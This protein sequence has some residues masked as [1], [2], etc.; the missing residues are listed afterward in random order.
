[1]IPFALTSPHPKRLLGRSV[2]PLFCRALGRYQ[3]TDRHVY[4]ATGR[5]IRPS[6]AL[7]VQYTYISRLLDWL[8]RTSTVA[9]CRALAVAHCGPTPMTCG[10]CSCRE[11]I[12]NSVIGVSRQPV[13]DC[14]T[15]FHLDS[16]G[17]DLP[18]T[19]SGNLWKLIYLA[20]E[21][22]IDSF[23]FIGAI[24]ISLYVYL[25]IYLSIRYRGNIRC[26]VTAAAAAVCD[27]KRQR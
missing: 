9:F 16:G 10:S 18:S 26:Y 17:R 8:P 7:V 19:L 15:T 5:I 27:D 21:A 25:S 11:H 2:Q 1:M 13:L 23:E 3:Q 6:N 12:I 22:L 24:Q 4:R 14:G 20:T